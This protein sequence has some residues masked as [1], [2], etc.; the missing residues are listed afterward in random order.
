MLTFNI[1]IFTSIKYRVLTIRAAFQIL[2]DQADKRNLRDFFLL[3]AIKGTVTVH[4]YVRR[5]MPSF[6]TVNN[7]MVSEGP[8]QII[9]MIRTLSQTSIYWR[10]EKVSVASHFLLFQ[11][12]KTV[13]CASELHVKILISKARNQTFFSL[14]FAQFCANVL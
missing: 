5:T 14:C 4:K 11:C 8:E 10:N 7:Q 1:F 6:S 13:C 2:K 12:S 3:H 9:K